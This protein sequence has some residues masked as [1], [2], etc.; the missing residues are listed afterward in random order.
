MINIYTDGSCRDNFRNSLGEATGLGGWAFVILFQEDDFSDIRVLETN[1]GFKIGS[2]NQEMEILAL[3]KA[4]DFIKKNNFVNNPI[5][6]Y[7]D[8]AYVV[9]C[10]KER[11]YDKWLLNDWKNSKGNDVQNK[12]AWEFLLESIDGLNFDIFHI[13]RN[14]TKYMKMVDEMAK[15]ALNQ[16]F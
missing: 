4:F 16:S 15:L 1:S 11:W 9:N 5:F 8:S 6:A 13:K 7:S 12:E 3:A 14:S 10:I 2:T